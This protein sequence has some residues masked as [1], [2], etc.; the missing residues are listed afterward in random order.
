MKERASSGEPLF[1]YLT[2]R[3]HQSGQAREIEIWFT[4]YGGRY[5][6]I[7]EHGSRAQWVRNIMAHSSISFRVGESSFKGKGRVVDPARESN[8]NRTIQQL[9]EKKYGW[10]DGLVV[11]LDP[12]EVR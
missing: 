1:L 6:I 9:S 12:T 8:L 10:G 4:Q 2:T 5:Y 7:A 3:G 11:E